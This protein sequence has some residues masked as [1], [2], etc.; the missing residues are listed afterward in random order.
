M[1]GGSFISKGVS[2]L[3]LPFF[4]FPGLI[5]SLIFLILPFS[6][7]AERTKLR[8]GRSEDSSLL[9]YFFFP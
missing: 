4:F 3:L 8:A 1:L 6:S 7:L 9:Y 5:F 2:A